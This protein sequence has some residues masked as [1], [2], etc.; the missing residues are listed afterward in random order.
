MLDIMDEKKYIVDRHV[1]VR[2]WIE[3]TLAKAALPTAEM[4]DCNDRLEDVN[5]V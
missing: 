2:A 4:L 5:W 3:V 1:S